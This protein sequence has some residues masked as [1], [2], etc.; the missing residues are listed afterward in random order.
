MY[1]VSSLEVCPYLVFQWISF[2]QGLPTPA[3]SRQKSTIK[4]MFRPNRVWQPIPLSDQKVIDKQHE[5]KLG[6][7][8]FAP[9][10]FFTK[11][12]RVVMSQTLTI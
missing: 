12:V 2:I 3:V 11:K 1:N 7:E 6:K 9:K 8:N 10:H 4:P 5:H